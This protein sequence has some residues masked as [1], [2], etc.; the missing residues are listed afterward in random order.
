MRQFLLDRSVDRPLR[1]PARGGDARLVQAMRRATL[2]VATRLSAD[3]GW[4]RLRC[5]VLDTELAY[6]TA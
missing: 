5:L 6:R 3:D 4:V 2:S 1:Y